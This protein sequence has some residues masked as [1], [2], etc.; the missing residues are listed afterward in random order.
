MPTGP[1]RPSL[2]HRTRSSSRVLPAPPACAYVHHPAGTCGIHTHGRRDEVCVT[3]LFVW[4]CY[5]LP[6]SSAYERIS[7]TFGDSRLRSTEVHVPTY[8][9][10]PLIGSCI[11]GAQTRT[12]SVAPQICHTPRICARKPAEDCVPNHTQNVQHT[13]T[14]GK[15][16]Q[17][18]RAP[19]GVCRP[20]PYS[21]LWHIAW[22]IQ[23]DQCTQYSGPAGKCH[24]H[25][26]CRLT[27][28]LEG[29]F[30][31]LWSS[32]GDYEPA[33]PVQPSAL[34]AIRA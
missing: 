29:C 12:R 26:T 25:D 3:I 14:S 23:N 8:L 33:V 34:H 30:V 10:S 20:V 13:R 32:V 16:S 28:R 19:H 21:P 27:T 24:E 4:M 7:T 9:T 5:S 18:S 22:G 31:C 11:Q 1:K 15:R 2:S 6:L 17:G